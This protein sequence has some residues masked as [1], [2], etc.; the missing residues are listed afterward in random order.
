MPQLCLVQ[1]VVVYQ[2]GDV[3]QFDDDP[4]CNVSI[5][6]SPGR[7]PG[8]QGQR[9]PQPFPDPTEHILNVVADAGIE[10]LHL[11]AQSRFHP[12]QLSRNR[13][14]QFL[15]ASRLGSGWRCAATHHRHSHGLQS[16]GR[17]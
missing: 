17:A 14:E 10:S 1:H 7:A 4:Q 6:D 9:W 12:M 5:V 15:Q 16:T 11:L 3:D 13:F 8:K 2:R